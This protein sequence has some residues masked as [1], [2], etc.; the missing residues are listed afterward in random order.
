MSLWPASR[1][2]FYTQQRI[3]RRLDRLGSHLRL[4]LVCLFQAFGCF[5]FDQQ[6]RAIELDVAHA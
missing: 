4:G 3:L 1:R 2:R 5:Q 6:Q